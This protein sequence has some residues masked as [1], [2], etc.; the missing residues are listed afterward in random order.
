[1]SNGGSCDKLP[2]VFTVVLSN[3]ILILAEPVIIIKAAGAMERLVEGPLCSK[4]PLL[5]VSTDGFAV[6]CSEIPVP[7]IGPD[8]DALSLGVDL[9][10]RGGLWV[11]GFWVVSD[12][13]EAFDRVL[14]RR[15]F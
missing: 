13:G 7:G 6:E 8:P 11:F 12:S 1:M 14:R 2:V 15:F 3:M 4:K 5:K 10:N 9:E